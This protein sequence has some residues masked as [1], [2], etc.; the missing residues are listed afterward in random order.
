M[1]IFSRLLPQ[2]RY[3]ITKEKCNKNPNLL[4]KQGN[5]GNFLSI[6]STDEEDFNIFNVSPRYGDNYLYNAWVNIAVNILIRN[7]ARADFIIKKG[8]TM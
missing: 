6:S 4:H 5:G 3:N 7:I 1:S 2:Y 8:G